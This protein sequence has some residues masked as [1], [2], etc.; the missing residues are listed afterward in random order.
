MPRANPS[1]AAPSIASQFMLGAM[2][3]L[4][5][6]VQLARH[7]DGES[8][9]PAAVEIVL[10]LPALVCWIVWRSRGPHAALNSFFI[11]AAVII[12]SVCAVESGALTRLFLCTT[13]F[14]AGALLMDRLAALYTRLEQARDDSMHAAK[15]IFPTWAIVLVTSTALLSL[16]L[17]TQSGVPDYRH[18]FWLHVVTCG[19]A[20]A[21]ASCLVGTTIYSLGEDFSA[22]GKSLLIVVNQLSAL[23]FLS[24]GCIMLRQLIGARVT[25]RQSLATYAALAIA[26]SLALLPA[27][28]DADAPSATVRLLWSITAAAGALADTG[29]LLR[30]DGFAAYLGTRSAFF[31]L[32][33]CAIISTL[34]I[35]LL[36]ELI[37]APFNRNRPDALA[38]E[39]CPWRTLGQWEAGAAF[40][41]LAIA[42]TLLFLFESPRFL[43]DK[44]FPERP[45][46]FGSNLVPMQ[47]MI[48]HNQRWNMAVFVSA[49][50]RSAGLQSIPVAPG[51]LSWPSFA[52]LLTWMTIG[53]SL[54]GL[55]G[56][57]RTGVF[58]L[59][60]LVILP[61]PKGTPVA[62][63][64]TRTRRTLLV[65]LV[66]FMIAW[67]AWNVLCILALAAI[68]DGTRYELIF[69]SIAA[70]NGVALSTG[71]T[72]HLTW[73]GR[74]LMIFIMVAGRWAPLV[75]WA[76]LCTAAS[77]AI[78]RSPEQK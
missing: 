44:F 19:H 36:I 66:I 14:I 57:M 65:R 71:L 45:L 42:A 15:I 7:A 41:M 32:T 8:I 56:G 25:L 49:T 24:L 76:G 21:S 58:T 53:G 64:I 6:A 43:D 55:A 2:S 50:L 59:M 72:L 13:C 37:T 69:E 40:G 47:D 34:G 73:L 10:Q 51:G 35:P 22:F 30:P 39:S 26:A 20:A 33:T 4:A 12:G 27:W 17:A 77:S 18:N 46:D 70:S 5:V 29:L 67:I 31:V 54:A 3:A 38:N 11:I 62:P 60:S 52:L 75:A 48:Q 63:N 9:L 61:A 1:P 23:A 28:R 16:P 68:S 74:L 78:K